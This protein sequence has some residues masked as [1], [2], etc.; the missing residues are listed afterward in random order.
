MKNELLKIRNKYMK[1]KTGYWY[2]DTNIANFLL[3]V[4]N[5]ATPFDSPDF[6]YIKDEICYICEHFEF[7]ASK[8][9]S[10]G[11]SLKRAEK[12]AERKINKQTIATLEKTQYNKNSITDCG[13]FC[14]NVKCIQNKHYWKDNF[15]KI[16][17][18]HYDNIINYKNNL[19]N[20]KIIN[21]N[22]KVK[23]IFIIED[24]TEFGA[25]LNKETKYVCYPICFDFGINTLRNANEID[26]VIFLNSA[27]REM[28]L[29]DR[30][31]FN[32]MQSKL[33][34]DQCEMFFFNKMV[35]IV[36]I[37]VVPDKLLKKD[38]Q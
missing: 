5:K 6:Y 11:S 30:N 23:N 26:Y 1:P 29:I 15:V 20:N 33:D 32:N 9:T 16:F 18:A 2:Y 27:I 12:D 34:F 38:N 3:E 8:N 31:I 35:N 13:S 36:A 24:T 22:T 19:I 14:E 28:I 25:F 17:K 7:D 21:K 4:I 37:V 10:K